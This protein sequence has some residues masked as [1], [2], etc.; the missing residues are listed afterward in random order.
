M[1]AFDFELCIV[2]NDVPRESRSVVEC[3]LEIRG[4]TN[5]SP[6]PLA[7]LESTK[8]GKD[9]ATAS[10][11]SRVR[12][13]GIT[14]RKRMHHSRRSS[15]PRYASAS[16]VS[17]ASQLPE[18]NWVRG[19]DDSR[20]CVKITASTL[21]T[22]HLGKNRTACSRNVLPTSTT[23]FLG[24]PLTNFRKTT[25]VLPR[26]FFHPSGTSGWTAL[27]QL[28]QS[29][30]LGHFPLGSYEPQGGS[31]GNRSDHADGYGADRVR[32]G[33]RGSPVEVPV[34]RKH[35]CKRSGSCISIL[36]QLG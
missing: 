36:L 32:Q 19:G 21:F 7:C 1:D 10:Y 33:T 27:L 26:R 25:L 15:R 22:P 11:V 20:A 31:K 28:A 24:S 29:T 23:T 8:Y 14:L 2:C 16:A 35:S 17:L 5:I 18:S 30:L 12:Y 6:P 34:P 13:T 3:S 9:L 4:Q